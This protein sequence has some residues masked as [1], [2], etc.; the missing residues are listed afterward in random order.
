[1]FLTQLLTQYLIY[2]FLEVAIVSL[3][4][5]TLAWDV[6]FRIEKV[7]I[8]FILNFALDQVSIFSFGKMLLIGRAK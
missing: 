1:M 3:K 5:E 8:K 7:Y 2:W 4:T 6:S